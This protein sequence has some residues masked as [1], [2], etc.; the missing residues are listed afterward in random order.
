MRVCGDE[1]G[2]QLS[3]NLLGEDQMLL[4]KG[5]KAGGATGAGAE[6]DWCSV[7]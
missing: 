5:L 4:A 3:R 7:M 1:T 2:M 6:L